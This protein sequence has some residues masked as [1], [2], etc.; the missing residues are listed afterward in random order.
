MTRLPAGFRAAAVSAGINVKGRPDMA[1]LV[2][3]VPAT[4]AGVFTTNRAAAAPVHLCRQHLAEGQPR[5]I[6]IN[7]GNANACTGVQGVQDAQRMAQLVAESLKLDPADVLVCSTGGIGKHLPMTCVE[8][9]LGAC[10]QQLQY[11]ALDEAAQAIMTTDTVPKSGE[12]KIQIEG[13]EVTLSAVAKGSGMIEPNMA[14]MLAFVL[15]DA[16]VDAEALQRVLRQ[17]ADQSFNRI[18]VD[19]DESTNDSLIMLANGQAGNK[20]LHPAH[21]DWH[22]FEEALYDICRYLALAMIRDGEGATKAVTIDICEAETDADAE[23]AARAVARSLLVKTGWAGT[24]SC[25]GRVIAAV[26]YS[27]AEMIL[28][29]ASIYYDDCPAMVAGQAGTATDEQLAQ[30]LSQP[31]FHVRVQLG[32]G[33]GSARIY[34]CNCTADYVRINSEYYT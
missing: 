18:S 24:Y 20:P 3:D 12:R 30:V 28:E 25:W 14:T 34:T 6:I 21:P 7:S 29:K 17:A 2:S 8:Q 10:V 16:A 19:G 9:G 32:L 11:G 31:T 15:T 27:G 23:M 26:G 4:A 33:D 5:A 1:L 13:R 22:V